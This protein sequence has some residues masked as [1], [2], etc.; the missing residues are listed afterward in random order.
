MSENVFTLT[1][2]EQRAIVAIILALL[3]GTFAVHFRSLRTELP[4]AAPSAS[5]P[6]QEEH[7]ESD[8]SR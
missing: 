5:T 4:K 1:K 8:D 2:R 6:P 3:V 7:G